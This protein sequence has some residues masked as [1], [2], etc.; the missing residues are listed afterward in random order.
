MEILF[1]GFVC[2][3]GAVHLTDVQ[4]ADHA[5]TSAS[6]LTRINENPDNFISRFVTVDETWLHHF[7]HE[8]KA[9]SMTWKRVTSPPPSQFHMFA[10]ACKVMATVFWDSEGIVLS[11]YLEHIAELLQEPTT[12]I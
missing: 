8:S 10:S 5:E 7:D 1:Y 3:I 11:D 4:K 9:Q 2:T 6:L 12:P